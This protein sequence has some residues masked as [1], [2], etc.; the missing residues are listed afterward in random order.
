MSANNTPTKGLGGRKLKSWELAAQN[1]VDIHQ[2]MNDFLK[3]IEHEPIGPGLAAI[4][5]QLTSMYESNDNDARQFTHD[6][7]RRFQKECDGYE[8]DTSKFI[9]DLALGL[10]T[11]IQSLEKG[12]PIP[13]DWPQQMED[14]H[15]KQFSTFQI[16][17]K[18]KKQKVTAV[19][20]AKDTEAEKNRKSVFVDQERT[21]L[22]LFWDIKKSIDSKE[23]TIDEVTSALALQTPTKA[24]PSSSFSSAPR[25]MLPSTPTRSTST[26]SGQIPA[27]PLR[28]PS[29]KR[30]R[31]MDHYDMTASSDS[32][33]SPEN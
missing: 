24:T 30:Q 15:N 1:P 32:A 31:T 6:L 27:G 11:R 3:H 12:K 5:K 29:N 2:N 14:W 23:R 17:L 26:P 9:G 28:T 4:A 21:L 22:A 33:D 20:G 13:E 25:T 16:K 19:L 18:Q 7:Q 8:T 10:Q